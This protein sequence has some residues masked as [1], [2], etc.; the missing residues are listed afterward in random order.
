M[1]KFLIRNA[2]LED[3]EV[4]AGFNQSIAMETEGRYLD[5]AVIGPGVKALLENPERGFYLVVE[6]GQLPVACLLVTYEW[7][8]WR[9]GMFWWIQSVNVIKDFRRQGIYR[10]MYEH[11]KQMAETEGGICGFR[12]YAENENK[13]AHATYRA[14][15]MDKCQY[16]MF[17]ELVT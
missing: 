10:R 4:I 14:M 5:D 11:L 1:S 2:Q 8:D 13:R 3:A 7:S 6:V 9:N 16:Q 12:L 15:G 17:E